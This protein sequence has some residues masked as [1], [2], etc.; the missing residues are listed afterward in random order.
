LEYSCRIEA[1]T[2][3]P[4]N[5]WQSIKAHRGEPSQSPDPARLEFGSKTPDSMGANQGGDEVGWL[6]GWLVCFV[7]FNVKTGQH[8]ETLY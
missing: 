8:M 7:V 3:V 5:F 1:T 4:P 2:D 6:V